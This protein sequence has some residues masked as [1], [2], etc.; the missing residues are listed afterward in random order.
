MRAL[1]AVLAALS[2]SACGTDSKPSEQPREAEKSVA[3]PSEAQQAA[4]AP[5]SSVKCYSGKE[6]ILQLS[7]IVADSW[8]QPTNVW[9]FRDAN[10]KVTSFYNGG[11]CVVEQEKSPTP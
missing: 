3:S 1:I 5:T 7:G 11:P 8:D 2:L 4:P 6:V 10:G 9:W